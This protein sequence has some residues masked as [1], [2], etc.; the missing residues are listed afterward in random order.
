M[1]NKILAIRGD[2]NDGDKVFSILKMLYPHAYTSL[3][4]TENEFA[5]FYHEGGI[6]FGYICDDFLKDH[7]VLSVD[8]FWKEY[9]YIIG[10]HIIFNDGEMDIISGVKWDGFQVVY[11]MQS[12]LHQGWF[13]IDM[14]T[15]ID[16][17]SNDDIINNGPELISTGY[18]QMDKIV[19][20]IFNNA[21]YEDEVELQLGDYE[22]VER[23]G[24]T[25]AVKK[26]PVYPKTYEECYDESNTE[27][28]FI[29][30]DKDERNSYESFIQLI[31]CRNA[32][33]KIAGE[34]MCL[35]RPWRPDWENYN[36]HKYCIYITEN[37]VNTGLFYNDNTILAFPTKE[38]RDIFY[39]N[40]KDLI[41]QCKELI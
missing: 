37:T 34:E 16:M 32:Y 19:S 28:H 22:I 12:E 30:V 26:K 7:I 6:V 20:V 29:Y 40:F 17:A 9:P 41:E 10:D 8:D 33:W 25:Y 14:F 35:D 1:K 2:R 24:K 5:Y 27:L 21:N 4:F 15:C 38:M 3:M 31:R 18:I 39:E 11:S 23:E 13:T 36:E